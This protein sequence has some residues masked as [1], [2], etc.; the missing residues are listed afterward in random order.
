MLSWFDDDSYEIRWN[1]NYPVKHKSYRTTQ[2]L[3]V[4]EYT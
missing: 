1:C 3:I 2:I 4:S